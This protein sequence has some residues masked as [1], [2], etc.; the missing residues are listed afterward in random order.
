MNSISHEFL[1]RLKKVRIQGNIKTTGIHKG[2]RR[3]Q[4]FGSSLEFSDF[5]TYQPGDD[6]RL[7]D[8]NVYSRTKRHYIKRHLDEQ[9]MKIA[10]YLDC[11]SSMRAI[12]EKWML[13]KQIAACL[14][15]I[16][17]ENEDRL[18][19][20][21]IAASSVRG[22]ERKGSIFSKAVLFN[23]MNINI[24]ETTSSFLTELDSNIQKGKQI[25]FIISD[26]LERPEGYE[27]IFRKLT[28]LK[29]QVV[30]IQVLTKD[31]ISPSYSGDRKLIDSEQNTEINISFSPKLIQIYENRVKEHLQQL[32]SACKQ[33]STMYVM[34][35]NTCSLEEILLKEFVYRGILQ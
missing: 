5:R 35:D 30:F 20:Y 14:S 2:I 23:I 29:S 21:P 11:T 12:N 25:S 9:E 17:L 3:S 34:V 8:W 6:V 19:F 1:A 32:E 13:A 10:I 7:I 24:G 28:T 15:F 16:C 27:Q 18:S 22:V 33:T 31:E 26:G 4:K